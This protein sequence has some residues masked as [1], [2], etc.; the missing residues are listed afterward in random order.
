MDSH[1]LPLAR[2]SIVLGS[3]AEKCNP[4]DEQS[5]AAA[6]WQ[7]RV[8]WLSRLLYDEMGKQCCFPCQ[9]NTIRHR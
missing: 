5:S 1:D 9:K 3:E 4:L 6:A 2:I 8:P 7:R